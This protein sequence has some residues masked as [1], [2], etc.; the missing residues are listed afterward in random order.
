M[1]FEPP[2]KIVE[3]YNKEVEIGL[4]GEKLQIPYL[5]V[6][7][8]IFLEHFDKSP[9]I[10]VDNKTIELKGKIYLTQNSFKYETNNLR[11]V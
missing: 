1:Y 8:V 7:H 5:I 4:T 10:I 6:F 9:I 2:E 11:V 3:L